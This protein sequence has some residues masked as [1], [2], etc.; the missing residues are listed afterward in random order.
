MNGFTKERQELIKYCTSFIENQIK[1]VQSVIDSAKESAQNE[2]KSSAGDKHETGKSLMQLEQ[3]NNAMLLDN[4]LKQKPAIKVLE[5]FKPSSTVKMGSII[6]ASNG[7][8]YI[9]IGIGVVKLLGKDYFIISP[10]APVGKLFMGKQKGDEVSFNGKKIQI[11][12]V[13]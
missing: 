7:I 2:S 1:H 4:M 11:V 6:Q 12:E 3:E 8:Y 9:G 10:T 13:R 5:N